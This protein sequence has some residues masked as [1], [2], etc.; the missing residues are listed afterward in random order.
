[1]EARMKREVIWQAAGGI[2]EEHL[3]LSDRN[4]VIV[5]DSFAIAK[6][7]EVPMRLRYQVVCDADWVT[8][9]V[10]VTTE[11]AHGSP[12]VIEMRS[13]GN[14]HWSNSDGSA[15]PHLDGC[16]DV[17]INV[18]PYTNTLPIRRL[19]LA[20]GA[21]E[22]ITVVYINVETLSV[23]PREQ[24]YTRLSADT[25]RY[26]GVPSGFTAELAVDADGLVRNYPGLWTRTWSG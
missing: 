14:G 19:R 9:G 24:R 22:T 3:T 4:G 11:I 18:T 8:R 10:A 21:T 2:G 25:V 12:A 1:M 7:G 16:I 5:A 15:L 6:P 23:E 20:E 13:D 26:E 17:D